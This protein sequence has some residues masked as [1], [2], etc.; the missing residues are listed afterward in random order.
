[1]EII[2]TIQRSR[3]PGSCLIN[4]RPGS[5]LTNQYKGNL[6]SYLMRKSNTAFQKIHFWTASIFN[7]ALV[8]VSRTNTKA[9]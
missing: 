4:R 9:I 8:R 5:C 7:P 2:D 6:N 3:R 1:M